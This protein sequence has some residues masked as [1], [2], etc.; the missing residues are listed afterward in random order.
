ML[1]NRILCFMGWLAFLMIWFFLTSAQTHAQT[2]SSTYY[3]EPEGGTFYLY[4]VAQ[5]RMKKF[6]N[7]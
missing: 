4:N 5:K 3:S 7:L 6:R 2:L 1:R